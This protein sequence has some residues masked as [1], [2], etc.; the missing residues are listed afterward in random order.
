MWRQ[1]CAFEAAAAVS[2]WA[3]SRFEGEHIYARI[4]RGNTASQGL[5]RKLG[6]RRDRKLERAEQEIDAD[7][8]VFKRKLVFRP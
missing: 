8:L 6:M 2:E 4:A 1:G 7:T 3:A 5:A